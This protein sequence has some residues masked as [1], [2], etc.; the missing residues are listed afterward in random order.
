MK[1]IKRLI[2]NLKERLR[3]VMIP[4]KNYNSN[5]KRIKDFFLYDFILKGS[6]LYIYT[7]GSYDSNKKIGGYSA[8]ILNGNKYFGI[9]ND[10]AYTNTNAE[11]MEIM[12][13]IEVLKLLKDQEYNIK[14]YIDNS[15]VI[16]GIQDIHLRQRERWIRPNGRRYSHVDLWEELI[17]LLES[18]NIFTEHIYSHSE[19]QHCSRHKVL[20]NVADK[21]AKVGRINRKKKV[22]KS[23]VIN[24]INEK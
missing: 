14:L 17:P 8:V 4:I 7:D 21:M 1:S 16:E 6:T 15:N 24:R 2:D 23:V 10:K 5:R 18:N 20:N 22:D 13:I 9:F 11:R 19:S 3:I 12:A